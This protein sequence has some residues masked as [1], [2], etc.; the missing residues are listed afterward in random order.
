MWTIRTK[1]I[2]VRVYINMCATCLHYDFAL[3]SHMLHI[4][5]FTLF[6]YQKKAHT[7]NKLLFYQAK[8]NTVKSF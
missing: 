4:A 6:P 8:K 7:K 2:Y 3:Y 5:L 1:Y